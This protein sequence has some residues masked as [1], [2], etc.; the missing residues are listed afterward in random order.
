MEMFSAF[1]LG[2]QISLLSEVW[3]WI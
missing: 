1:A 2:D 3:L